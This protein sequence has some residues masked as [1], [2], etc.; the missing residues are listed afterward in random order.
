MFQEGKKVDEIPREEGKVQCEGLKPS[1]G[2]TR[3]SFSRGTHRQLQ[4]LPG[5]LG[6]E[7]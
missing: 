1:P 6:Q 7:D 4:Q 5:M 2:N 3:E